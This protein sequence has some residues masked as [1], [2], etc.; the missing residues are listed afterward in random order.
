MTIVFDQPGG[1]RTLANIPPYTPW[2]V[3]MQRGDSTDLV[4]QVGGCQSQTLLQ[5]ADITKVV[6]D[7]PAE[8]ICSDIIEKIRT[9]VYQHTDYISIDAM[10]N[11]V[12]SAHQLSNTESPNT[13]TIDGG[14]PYQTWKGLSA[15]FIWYSI[16]NK[17]NINEGEMLALFSSVQ[18][19]LLNN[20]LVLHE[21]SDFRADVIRRKYLPIL[22]DILIHEFNDDIEID[23][24]RTN[25]K[26]G[27]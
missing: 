10:L 22:K 17:L 24:I 26:S 13:S 4:L 2:L 7:I 15:P 9:M 27:G 20:R 14:A 19:C 8:E 6:P 23:V 18:P 12:L 25:S 3:S 21:N 16:L 1:L 11:T 5:G